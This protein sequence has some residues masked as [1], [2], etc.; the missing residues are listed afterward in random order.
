M[1]H[2]YSA[3]CLCRRCAREGAR[4]LL[5]GLHDRRRIVF[6]DERGN[7]RFVAHLVPFVGPRCRVRRRVRRS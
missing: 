2:S 3:D 6:C 4:R 1:K 7:V 5:Q